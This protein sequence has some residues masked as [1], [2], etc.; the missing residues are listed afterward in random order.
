MDAAPVSLLTRTTRQQPFQGDEGVFLSM[1]CVCFET[2][3][4]LFLYLYMSI[5]TLKD[6]SS[7]NQ[8]ALH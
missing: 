7:L 1:F 5:H 8:D 3:L 4:P 2:S 6:N